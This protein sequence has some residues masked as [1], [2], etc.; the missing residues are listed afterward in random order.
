MRMLV[1][2]LAV[3]GCEALEPQWSGHVSAIE[4]T[5]CAEVCQLEGRVCMANQCA[6]NTLA[7]DED[8]DGSDEAF[9]PGACG[10]AI[11]EVVAPTDYVA[12]CCSA[13]AE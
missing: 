5:T 13:G 6:G 10:E 2:A 4:D 1:L 11:G 7:V 12:C 8:A 9:V 3:F